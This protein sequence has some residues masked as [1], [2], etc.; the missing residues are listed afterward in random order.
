MFKSMLLISLVLALI[1]FGRLVW[2]MARAGALLGRWAE[3]SGFR[4]LSRR[5]QYVS[6]LSFGV[7]FLGLPLRWQFLKY[8][9]IFHVTGVDD[10]GEVKT[11]YILSRPSPFLTPILP[12][13]VE[14]HWN[15]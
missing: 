11:G 9:V 1:L 12:D 10:Q 2:R 15:E 4:I 8:R 13:V 3:Q 14:A 6:L 7:V 5:L